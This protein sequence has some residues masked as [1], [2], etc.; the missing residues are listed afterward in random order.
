MT[1][2]PRAKSLR[3]EHTEQ[4]RH[5][6]VDAATRLFTERGYADTSID[7]V[8]GAARVTRGA[9]YHH[10]AGK[11]AIFN[12]VCAA[13]D[14]GVV[15]RV[16]AAAAAPG[17]AEQR[18]RHVL[19][20]YFDA[21]GDAAYRAIVLGQSRQA[22]SA[23]EEQRYTPAMTSTIDE[24]VRGLAEAGEITADNPEMLRRLLCAI[25]YE[26]AADGPGEPADPAAQEYAKQAIC[27]LLFTDR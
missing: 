11:Q 9:L 12:A 27:R 25:L 5:A 2:A 1:A 19:D 21:S 15:D 8:A 16:R 18:L 22:R 14:A 20:V 23:G 7:D 10:F 13:V 4:T 3:Q 24:F 6:L 17:T 26:V